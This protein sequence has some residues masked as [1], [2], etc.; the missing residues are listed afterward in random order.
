MNA[1]SPTYKRIPRATV[2]IHARE[3]KFASRVMGGKALFNER[4]ERFTFVENEKRKKRSKLLLATPHA[5][6]RLRESG[7]FSVS[8]VFE[9]NEKYVSE[10]L[11]AEVRDL[12][13]KAKAEA[14]KQKP[15]N[16]EEVRGT[17]E[18]AS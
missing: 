15:K 2:E 12:V 4:E 16:N 9:H 3:E 6:L 18:S 10:S 11:L 5:T 8:I 7:I 17:A 14:L 13:K 1:E